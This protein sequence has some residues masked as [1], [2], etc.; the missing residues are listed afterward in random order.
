[1]LKRRG[2]RIQK[3]VQAI[4]AHLPDAILDE[5]EAGDLVWIE[6]GGIVALHNNVTDANY[7][8]LGGVTYRYTERDDGTMDIEVYREG[9]MLRRMVD[10]RTDWPR[11]G[12]VGT[13]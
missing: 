13:D 7:C 9:V 10:D 5:L 8:A 12:P 6:A 1:M 3:A 2:A 4:C 11:W